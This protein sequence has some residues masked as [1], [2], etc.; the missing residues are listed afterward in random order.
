M[1]PMRFPDPNFEFAVLLAKLRRV[2]EVSLFV[3]EI[4]NTDMAWYQEY[5]K[6]REGL[7]ECADK[8]LQDI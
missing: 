5:A 4:H 8:E 2:D 1:T 3:G 6:E 7:P